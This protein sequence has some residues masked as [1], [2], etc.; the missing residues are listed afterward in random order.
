MSSSHHPQCPGS[1]PRCA[2]ELKNFLEII[3][4]GWTWSCHW[5]LTPMQ[6]LG[7]VY[8]RFYARS[9]HKRTQAAQSL[10][11]APWPPHPPRPP[12]LVRVYVCICLQYSL[13]WFS[14]ITDVSMYKFFVFVG[15]LCS[16]SPLP[17]GKLTS[18]FTRICLCLS[19]RR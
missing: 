5:R 1:M 2:A 10:Y 9:T 8:A 7:C 11:P 17:T 6:T 14:G 15:A 18:V 13:G 4:I 16:I 19:N 12:S 3:I